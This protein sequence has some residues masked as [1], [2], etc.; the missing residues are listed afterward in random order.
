MGEL[1]TIRH[2]LESALVESLRGVFGVLMQQLVSECAK[3][4]TKGFGLIAASR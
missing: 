2:I 4:R 1:I 3:V